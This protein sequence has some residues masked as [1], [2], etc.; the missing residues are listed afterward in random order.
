MPVW[1]RTEIQEVL[2]EIKKAVTS[3]PFD[4]VTAVPGAKSLELV[5]RAGSV[6]EGPISLAK[7]CP[8]TLYNLRVGR[9]SMTNQRLATYNM[10]G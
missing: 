2:R 7:R 9:R 3:T 4:L 5:S 8:C 6:T 1:V 10:T